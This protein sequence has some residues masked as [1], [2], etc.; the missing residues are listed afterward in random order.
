MVVTVI[1]KEARRTMS[2]NLSQNT[3]PV[4]ITASYD[5]AGAIDLAYGTSDL[6]SYNDEVGVELGTG[7]ST[8]IRVADFIH[9]GVDRDVYVFEADPSGGLTGPWTRSGGIAISA[10]TPVSEAPKDIDMV[11]MA[12]PQGDPAPTPANL[13]AAQGSGAGLIRV[14]IR[15]IGGL[16]GGRSRRDP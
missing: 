8:E 6:S 5:S 12:V 13:S 1:M 14:K 2:Y 3:S 15:P 11:V 16:P 7:Y 9:G 4:Q 10:T